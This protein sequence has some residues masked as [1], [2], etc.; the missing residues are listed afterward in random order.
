MAKQLNEWLNEFVENGADANDVSNWPENA[1]GSSYTAGEGI[2]I[3]DDVISVDNT[4]ARKS[5]IPTTIT[6]TTDSFI[7][8]YQDNTTETITFLTDVSLS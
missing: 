3:T 2:D 8:T 4:I 6:K 7:I 1:G 5:D